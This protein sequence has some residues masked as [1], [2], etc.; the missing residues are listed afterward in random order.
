MAENTTKPE[1][2]DVQAFLAAVE[3]EQ[4]RADAEAVCELMARVTGRPPVMW[5][6]SIVGFG[7]YHYRYES[8]REG[9]APITG[10]SPRKAALVLYVMGGFPQHDELMVKLG[11]YT[12]GKSCLYI[13]RLADVDLGVLEAL[14]AES[15]AYVRAS[16][17]PR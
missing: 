9:D 11:K 8:G 6:T 15:V 2:A 3:P 12:T 1:T 17:D 7:A 5:G 14:V 4:R 13:K 10:F 16:Y